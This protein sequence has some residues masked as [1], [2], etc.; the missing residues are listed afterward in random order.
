M[1][2]TKSLLLAVPF[3]SITPGLA[4]AADIAVKSAWVRG[5]VPAQMMSGAFMEITSKNA[6]TL[7]GVTTPVAEEAE[8]HEMRLEGGVMKMRAAPRLD[9]PA[10]KTVV[11][12][13]GGYH[14]MLMGLKRQLKPGD[15]VPLTLKI[16]SA[17]K[18]VNTAVVNAE[19]REL[20]EPSRPDH[21]DHMH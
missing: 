4:S 16:E 13:P 10:G 1:K 3:L 9:L 12:K 19:V 17:N 11:L 6:A 21:H 18:K 8:V 14:V 20:S 2:P 5:T 7:V 15:M